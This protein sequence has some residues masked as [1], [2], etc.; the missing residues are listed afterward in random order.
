M[1]D[2]NFVK[3]DARQLLSAIIACWP[4]MNPMGE[5]TVGQY[6]FIRPGGHG[7]V[8]VFGT[9]GHR[10]HSAECDLEVTGSMV[11]HHSSLPALT[12]CLRQIGDKEARF[13]IGPI[14]PIKEIGA[15]H[16]IH[17]IWGNTK[18]LAVQ[19]RH[20]TDAG[21]FAQPIP[22]DERI[23]RAQ[24]RLM[25]IWDAEFYMEPSEADPLNAAVIYNVG[26]IRVQG[27]YL[28]DAVHCIDDGEEL[29]VAI[30]AFPSPIT[31]WSRDYSR[32]ATIMPI[33]VYTQ[34]TG[35]TS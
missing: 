8:R 19:I 34:L 26:G 10:F 17:I 2:E 9:D 27:W 21:I 7:G 35:G 15:E 33:T 22:F 32:S 1:S 23:C 25:R 29:P 6:L 13:W 14:A 4:V 18:R 3:F 12:A 11:M 31:I 16:A 5:M 24:P 20:E 30:G 28:I